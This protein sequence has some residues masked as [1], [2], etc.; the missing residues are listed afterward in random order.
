MRRFL[1]LAWLLF[2]PSHSGGVSSKPRLDVI[3]LDAGHGGKDAGAVGTHGYFEKQAALGIVL[4]LGRLIEKELPGTKVVYTRKDDRFVELYRRGEIANEKHAKL[5][6]SVHCNST[7]QKPSNA[8]GFTSYILRPGKTDQAI[9]VAARENA[10]ISYEKERA[11]YHELT[12]EDFIL[13]SMARSQDVKYSEKFA[14]L[15]QK[16]LSKRLSIR[17]DGVSQ[18]GFL[19]LVGAAMPNA[20]IETGFISNPKEEALLRSEKGQAD[21]ARAIFEA[22]KKYKSQYEKS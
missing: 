10:V 6:I 3:V 12:D 20:L 14:S 22:I 7:P 9:R 17:N 8:S 13:T 1:F 18:A 21:Y 19:V 4:K 11:R 16:E 5:F 15:V 2:A